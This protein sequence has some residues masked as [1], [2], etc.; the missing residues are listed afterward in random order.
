MLSVSRFDEKRSVANAI[1]RPSGDQA[2]C[3]SA[4]ASFVRRR[5]REVFRSKMYRSVSPARMPVKQTAWPSGAHVGLITS[6]TS[7]IATSRSLFPLCASKMASAGRPPVTVA[8]AM[9]L[10]ALSQAPAE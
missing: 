3:T 9:R 7:G 10:L 2:G 5:T 4:K 6:S 1:R 8:I